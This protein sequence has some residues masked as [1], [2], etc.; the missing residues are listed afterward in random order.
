MKENKTNIFILERRESRKL[1]SHVLVGK[2][3]QNTHAGGVSHWWEG[4]KVVYKNPTGN[5]QACVHAPYDTVN[6]LVW[7]QNYFPWAFSNKVCV[8]SSHV[9]DKMAWSQCDSWTWGKTCI[10]HQPHHEHLNA[11]KLMYTQEG[12]TEN[13]MPRGED[14]KE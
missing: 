6:L 1:N 7:I 13:I 10:K 8:S 11:M 5:M 14:T 12:A 4:V 9:C 2:W 3:V